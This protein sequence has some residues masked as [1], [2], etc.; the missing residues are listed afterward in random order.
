MA[1]AFAVVNQVRV[2]GSELFDDSLKA[3]VCSMI[4]EAVDCETLFAEDLLGGGI[5]GMSLRD[6]RRTLNS[7]LIN[8]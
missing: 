1:F 5:P 4:D 2:E 3:A 7:S 6:M 8:E